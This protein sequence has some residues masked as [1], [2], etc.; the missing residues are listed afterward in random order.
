MLKITFLNL[1]VR[2][3][4]FLFQTFNNKQNISAPAKKPSSINSGVEME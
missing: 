4:Y 3:M 2:L 1:F